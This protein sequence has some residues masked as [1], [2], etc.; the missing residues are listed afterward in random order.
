VLEG[1]SRD[2]VTPELIWNAQTRSELKHGLDIEVRKLDYVRKKEGTHA[3]WD[4]RAF[5]IDYPSYRNQ[6]LVD[7][8]FVD[9][10]VDA[11]RHRGPRKLGGETSVGSGIKTSPT[12]FVNDS[13]VREPVRL[14][15]HLYDRCVAEENGVWRILC[16]RAMRLLIIRHPDDIIALVPIRFLLMEVV[17]V[18]EWHRAQSHTSVI[19]EDDQM[20]VMEEECVQVDL[21]TDPWMRELLLLMLSSLEAC[22]DWRI[23]ASLV[24]E[25][26]RH[27][28]LP[29]LMNLF[30]Y[31]QSLLLASGRPPNGPTLSMVSESPS[32]REDAASELTVDCEE[33]EYVAHSIFSIILNIF[34]SM[35]RFSPSTTQLLSQC[36]VSCQC[37][38][39]ASI[40]LF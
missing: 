21:M 20:G 14:H 13:P 2:W 24:R 12:S 18:T 37:R 4:I 40:M 17:H 23:G 9:L 22:K 25:A 39:T 3:A 33:D 29:I 11:L 7:G 30:W 32:P 31:C 19:M 27:E 10:L 8:F 36:Q 1:V 16:L 35:A 26:I 34:V 15:W 5:E 6:L 28:C 38:L